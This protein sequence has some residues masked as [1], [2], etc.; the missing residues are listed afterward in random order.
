MRY[1]V[2]REERLDPDLGAFRPAI[3]WIW[4]PD[5]NGGR[6]AILLRPVGGYESAAAEYNEKILWAAGR[7]HWL[8]AV[9]EY[10]G[11]DEGDQYFVRRTA[12]EVVDYA[13]LEELYRVELA[14]LEGKPRPAGRA[15]RKAAEPDTLDLVVNG[16][17]GL[18]EVVDDLL[19]ACEKGDEVDLQ[20]AWEAARRRLDGLKPDADRIRQFLKTA[21]GEVFHLP[22]KHDQK[23]HG[24]RQAPV[25]SIKVGQSGKQKV[26]RMPDLRAWYPEAEPGRDHLRPLRVVVTKGRLDHIVTNPKDGPLRAKLLSEKAHLVRKAIESPELG[27]RHLELAKDGHWRHTM[28]V[29]DP[30]DPKHYV[31]VALSL[32]RLPGERHS[33]EHRIVTVYV[34]R[35]RE[36]YRRGEIREEWMEL[37]TKKPAK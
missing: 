27:R 25:A 18:A 34:S 15:P 3:L 26:G 19:A 11:R 20:A 8:R 10:F 37:G 9:W 4:D 12:P 28:A 33:K 5:G 1:E 13:D 30:D 32:A 36:F 31:V 16:L 17:A 22:G 6:G 23:D 2:M 14:A 29:K 24:K 21:R 7:G 35:E